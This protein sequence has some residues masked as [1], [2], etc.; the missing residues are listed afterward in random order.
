MD[1]RL[2]NISKGRVSRVDHNAPLVSISDAYTLPPEIPNRDKRPLLLLEFF[3][4]DH[5]TPNESRERLMTAEKASLLINFIEAQRKAGAEVIYFQCGEGRIR[6]YTLATCAWRY[7]EGYR[8]DTANAC[9]SQGIIDRYT[10]NMAARAMEDYLE[11][12]ETSDAPA[13]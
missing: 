3:P 5:A 13:N 12:Q 10:F 4:G 8:H 6:S 1:V 7:L 2:V 11:T 9:V